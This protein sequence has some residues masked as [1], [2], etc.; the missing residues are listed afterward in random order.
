MLGKSS[1]KERDDPFTRKLHFAVAKTATAFA[2][3]V[4]D[5]RHF[6]P[7]S[8]PF[9]VIPSEQITRYT[10]GRDLPMRGVGACAKCFT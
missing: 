5:V 10:G 4:L 9:G 2:T 6:E 8:I 3:C 7:L 1:I